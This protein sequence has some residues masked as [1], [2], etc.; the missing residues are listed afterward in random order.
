MEKQKPCISV[1]SHFYLIWK[2]QVPY[3]L[4]MDQ[5]KWSKTI[6]MKSFY[7]TNPNLHWKLGMVLL[8]SFKVC[9]FFFGDTRYW[10][11]NDDI[12]V[13]IEEFLLFHR[14]ANQLKKIKPKWKDYIETHRRRVEWK[15]CNWPRFVTMLPKKQTNKLFTC[16]W[17]D[18]GY[19]ARWLQHF[20]SPD[21]HITNKWNP[22]AFPVPLTWGKVTELFMTTM[23]NYHNSKFSIVQPCYPVCF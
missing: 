23:Y 12:C 18:H 1:F 6:Q 9:F 22:R 13:Y 17:L 2:H 20:S 4:R 21:A 11:S 19:G 3:K 15:A 14:E 5:R 16:R 7:F 8:F 10:F